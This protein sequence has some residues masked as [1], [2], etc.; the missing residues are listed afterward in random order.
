[1]SAIC[2]RYAHKSFLGPTKFRQRIGKKLRTA[3][4]PR[5]QEERK[6]TM[7]H[8]PNNRIGFRNR[9]VTKETVVPS[10]ILKPWTMWKTWVKRRVWISYFSKAQDQLPRD[11]YHGV[12]DWWYKAGNNISYQ[13]RTFCSMPERFVPSVHFWSILNLLL[14]ISL[15]KVVSGQTNWGSKVGSIDRYWYRTVALDV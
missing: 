3:F 4:C 1:M 13:A 14:I 7:L 9:P 11:N 6:K 12:S 10:R 15:L 2:I 8:F 5:E